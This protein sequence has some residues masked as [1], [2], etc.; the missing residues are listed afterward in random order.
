MTGARSDPAGA[1]P[2][3]DLERRGDPPDLE[4]RGGP[5]DLERHGG[6]PDL[7]RHGGPPDLERRVDPLD[8][9]RRAASRRAT[10]RPHD[11]AG[12]VRL[13]AVV[14]VGGRATRMGG[15]AKHLLTV[16]GATLFA[17]TVAALEAAGVAPIVAVGA[18]PV[19]D[20]SPDDGDASAAR[21][22][23]AREDPPFGGPVAALAAALAHPALAGAEEVL[24]L[25]GDLAHPE[26]V[27]ARLVG[28]PS[29]P[30][31]GADPDTHGDD[32]ARAAAGAAAHDDRVDRG[33][34]GGSASTARPADAIVL[35]SGGHA[36]WLSGRYRADALRAALVE[37]GAPAGASCRA[38]LG[39]LATWWI[40]DEDGITADIDTLDDLARARDLLAAGPHHPTD[41]RGGADMTDQKR[42]LPPEALDDWAAELRE[43]FGLAPEDLP[44]GL[45]LD[46]ARDVAQGV[47]RPAAPF[48]AFVA[49]LVAGR[50]GGSPDDVRAAVAAITE[51]AL[52]HR[53]D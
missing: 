22:A 1:R 7:E 49:G 50:A 10:P 3:P 14:L 40:E 18:P 16:G 11:P 4:R 45:I 12:A 29:A 48:S 5:P 42:T 21:V 26:A 8:L 13:G 34:G 33:W 27:I 20:A 2:D 9:E 35:R 15:A 32:R 43:R 17:R 52:A 39:A 6:P 46:L 30:L 41:P 51:L 44:I 36:Q 53:A 24:F 47:A 25:A 28:V 37:L 38:L 23:W 19:E 31:P